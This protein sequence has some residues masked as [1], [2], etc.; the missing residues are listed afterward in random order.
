MKI[1]YAIITL[2]AIFLLLGVTKPA[3]AQVSM[4]LDFQ[5]TKEINENGVMVTNNVYKMVCNGANQKTY[6]TLKISWPNGSVEYREG[7]Y[8]NATIYIAATLEEV[9]VVSA[10]DVKRG[11]DGIFYYTFLSNVYGG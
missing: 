10:N 2:L 3:Q 5:G 7:K 9:D 6:I 11:N 8:C 4:Y 1:R